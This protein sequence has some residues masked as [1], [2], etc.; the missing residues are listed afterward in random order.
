MEYEG[1]GPEV[2]FVGGRGPRG[3]TP[4]F[5]F[6]KISEGQ[7]ALALFDWTG[8][9]LPKPPTGFVNETEVLGSWETA[10]V[11]GGLPGASAYD[12]WIEEGNVG[13]KAEYLESLRGTDGELTAAYLAL[14]AQMKQAHLAAVQYNALLV[15]LY[16]SFPTATVAD[17]RGLE[18]V[19]IDAASVVKPAYFVAQLNG[20]FKYSA[21]EM[22]FDDAQNIL[23]D[24]SENRWV[25][26]SL[27]E[28]I[29]DSN[30]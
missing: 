9:K 8:G 12:V 29:Y 23:V 27:Y 13:T 26:T 5:Q 11:F 19:P 21:T 28:D 10:T 3:W 24:A 22:G 1:V 16:G 20:V 6:V 25:R 18:F 4:L 15:A 2:E 17:I 7:F 14:A 30:R